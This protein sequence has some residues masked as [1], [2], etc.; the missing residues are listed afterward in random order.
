MFLAVASN[1]SIAT[2]AIWD[3]KK[4]SLD[5]VWATIVALS[6]LVNAIRPY[7]PY[8]QRMRGISEMIRELQELALYAENKWYA[9][10]EGQLTKEQIHE[11]VM[12][13]KQRKIK[14][15]QNHL[16]STR[17]PLK[18]AFL[19]DA[20]GEAQKYFRTYYL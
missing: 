11:E 12:D 2:W 19:K 3:W 4:W 9:V 20:E 18:H 5:L 10:S 7:F 17:L 16:G 15:E 6:Q 14:A 1:G 8:Q 13:L